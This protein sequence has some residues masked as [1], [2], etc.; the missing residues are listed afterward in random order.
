MDDGKPLTYASY[1]R[2]DDLLA[3]QRRLT[4]A[5]DELQFIVVHQVFELWFTLL[6]FELES[7]RGAM[8]RGDVAGAIHLLR[9]AH[10]VLKTLTAG[11]AVIETMRPID[12][13]EFRS[14]LKPASGFQSRQFREIE[15]ISGAKDARYL[16]VFDDD[17]ASRLA[18]R[19]RYEEPTL[20]DE[21]AALLG[22]RGLTAGTHE[23]QVRACVQIQKRGPFAD[24]DDL[25]EA[26]IEYDLQFSAWRERHVLMT[27][28]MIGGRPGTGQAAV[29][30]LAGGGPVVGPP[31]GEYFSGVHY[32]KTTVSKR[33]FPIL[34][35]ARTF[36]ER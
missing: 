16:T 29:A 23:E 9:R 11:W 18:L 8:A 28:R 1:L 7:I 19:R 35:E 5:H 10:E 26:L 27:E 21:F 20:W 30:K 4:S 15:F 6:R 33:F 25:A 17:E 3:L 14:L 24:L 34:W 22:R 13:L 36:V 12:F 31:A 2:T 32:L